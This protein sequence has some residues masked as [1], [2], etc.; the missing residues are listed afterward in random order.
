MELDFC[1]DCGGPAYLLAA[2]ISAPAFILWR[3]GVWMLEVDAAPASRV[4]L[5]GV[6][7]MLWAGAAGLARVA[8]VAIG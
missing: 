1:S 8:W 6:A 4:V 7:L 3:V 5:R 2:G